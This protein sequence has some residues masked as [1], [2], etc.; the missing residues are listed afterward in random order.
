MK[1]V[2]NTSNADEMVLKTQEAG[3]SMLMMGSNDLFLLGP[4]WS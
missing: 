4:S 1:V 3:V 2:V